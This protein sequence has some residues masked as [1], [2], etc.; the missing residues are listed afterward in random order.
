MVFNN[1]KKR[2]L[3]LNSDIEI[4]YVALNAFACDAFR[5]RVE[6]VKTVKRRVEI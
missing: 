3:S 4:S 5:R 2:N 1:I 6:R